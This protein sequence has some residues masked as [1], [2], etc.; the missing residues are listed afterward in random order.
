MAPIPE[1]LLKARRVNQY[2]LEGE[3]LASFD[4][5]NKAAKA[6]NTDP[7]SISKCCKDKQYTAAG[8]R[9]QYAD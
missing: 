7:G 2:N 5:V 1:R 8:Y 3:L 6:A 9:W 4:S